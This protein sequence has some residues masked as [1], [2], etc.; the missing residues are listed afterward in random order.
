MATAARR[1]DQK[2]VVNNKHLLAGDRPAQ[3]LSRL[4]GLWQKSVMVE[5][6]VIFHTYTGE[7]H[8][9]GQGPDWPTL[10]A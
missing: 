9:I 3:F 6:L 4:R 2:D 1:H 10:L 7:G 5:A 8:I